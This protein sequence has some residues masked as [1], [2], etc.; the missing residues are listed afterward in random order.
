MP[1]NDIR[2]ELDLYQQIASAVG[3]TLEAVC[4]M[5]EQE[6]EELITVL[7]LRVDGLNKELVRDAEE[8][9]T[10]PAV[11]N[12]KPII[13]Q[14]DDT[15][16]VEGDMM[17]IVDP[18]LSTEKDQDSMKF[19]D[20]P[21]VEDIKVDDSKTV[22]DTNN[23]EKH[24][25]SIVA[26]PPDNLI[27][28]VNP[29]LVS[30][31]QDTEKVLRLLGPDKGHAVN[32]DLVLA[33]LEAHMDEVDRV[34]VVVEELA[35][36]DNSDSSTPERQP[37]LEMKKNEKGKGK[38]S[39]LVNSVDLET[40]L[41]AVRKRSLVPSSTRDAGLPKQPRLTEN[42]LEPSVA[43]LIA[44]PILAS[45][46]SSSVT[47]PAAVPT[48]PISSIPTQ[49]GPSNPPLPI[50]IPED[51]ATMAAIS[52][53]VD[54][55]S[56]MFP[57]TPL[58]YLRARCQD[59]VGK[60]AAVDR[61]TEELLTNQTPPAGWRQ[62]YSAPAAAPSS[63][64]ATSSRSE[65][66]QSPI[67]QWEEEKY[68]ELLSMFPT[69]SPDY[70]LAQVQAV[71][72]VEGRSSSGEVT[73]TIIIAFQS[74]VERIWAM[75]PDMRRQLPTR[76]QWEK[77]EKER[78]ELEKWSG[79]MTSGDFLNMYEDPAKYFTTKREVSEE[80][81]AH[82]L[83]ELKARFKY[84]NYNNIT[85][86][87]TRCGF[88]LSQTVK[89]LNQAENSRKTRRP[90]SECRAPGGPPCVTFLKE[91]KFLEL[92]E[93]IVKES[94]RRTQAK[95]KKLAAA[96]LAGVL[97]DCECCYD[98]EC[99]E[100]EMVRCG[101]DHLYCRDCVE[102][103]TKVA[104]GEGKTTMECLGQCDEEITWQELSRALPA[105]V[106]SKLIQ[107]RQAVEVEKAGLAGVVACPY[108]PYLTIMETEEDKVLVCRN[109]DC[110]RE[111][112]RL[113]REPNH[114][115]LRCDEVEKGEQA[116]KMIEEKLTEAM[117]RECAKCKNKFYKEEGCNK[118]TCRCGA[119]MCY[120]CKKE[121]VDYSHFYGQGGTA[122]TTKTCPLWSDNKHLHQMELAKAAEQAKLQ[123]TEGNVTLSNDPTKDIVMP[124][125]MPA[126]E[127]EVRDRL[128]NRWMELHT[129]VMRL[130]DIPKRGM[131]LPLMENIRRLIAGQ[132]VVAL[133]GQI[134][135]EL[136][137]VR[138]QVI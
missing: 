137:A 107:K 122:T 81:K 133:E 64:Q 116:R 8:K 16:N 30:L 85:R 22:N 89:L 58:D 18:V 51:P 48:P 93:D 112:C 35:G 110:G 114:I 46:E 78:V 50:V 15:A 121:G 102:T 92:E 91:K 111:S 55:L 37:S 90:D 113:C 129:R 21:E 5:Q 43:T 34:Q 132:Q 103:S 28:E 59:L 75:N 80:Y 31:Q 56:D 6:R 115:P 100:E 128:F 7:G 98:P 94:I 49:P 82:A 38:S 36:M 136:E 47:P 73:K 42:L 69:I 25:A 1:L 62:M 40:R 53:L 76:S 96:R 2:H 71:S 13:I 79:K 117:L 72:R 68:G 97:V 131:L 83:V 24:I 19:D 60:E 135:R 17:E 9:S 120:L 23:N 12:T 52:S 70:L 65:L 87:F 84:Q 99:L 26:A 4:N 134:T 54:S 45:R 3:E 61:F 124:A 33:Y 20:S 125:D 74:M 123:L 108:C 118:M 77:K 88:L 57:L 10:V 29:K 105:N 41:A 106:M 127:F 109:P 27:G 104:M 32:N 63:A 14:E 130:T 101:G 39:K 67:L 95:E 126:S 119:K 86:A 44:A 138:L 66:D 11:A